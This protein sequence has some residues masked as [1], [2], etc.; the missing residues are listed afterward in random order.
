[1]N[2]QSLVPNMGVRSVSETVKFYTEVLGFELI[3]SVPESGD[4]IF[5]IIGAGNISLMFQ[6]LE[7]LKEEYP[8]LK[9]LADRGVLTFYL[10]MKNKNRLYEKIRNTVYLVKAM[11]VT[12]Y[13]V[14]EFA[15]RD[16]NGFI[17]TIAEDEN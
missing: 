14:E 15:I 3:A 17:I 12:S 2:Y 10:K 1:M 5:A 11:N 16:N 4:L 6:E 8:E 13:G 7:S 9:G